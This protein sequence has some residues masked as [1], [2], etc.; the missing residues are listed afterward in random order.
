VS[1]EGSKLIGK[2]ISHYIILEKLGGGG[3]GE[4]YKA[5]DTKLERTIALKF[6]PPEFTRDPESK[7][8]FIHEAKVASKLEHINICNIH[9]IDE[10][11]DGQIFIAMACYDG[12]TL[13]DKIKNQRLKTEDVIDTAI[14][15]AQGLAKAHE[16]GITHCDIKPANIFITK[17][18][19]V[20]IVDFGIAKL[21]GQTM[22]TKIGMTAGTVAYMSPEQARGDI[23]DRRTDIWSLG[24]V[25]YE[26]LTNQLPFKGNYEQALVYSILNEEPEPMTNVRSELPVELEAVAK[27]MLQKNLEE[28]YENCQKLLADLKSIKCNIEMDFVEHKEKPLPSV[29]VLPFLNMSTDPEN[30]YFSE[31]LA[32][33]LIN[34]LSKINDF[35]IAA[36][37]S[38]F[39]FKGER[40]DIREIGQK[41]NV[42]TVLEGSVRKAG[43]RLR[44]T[45]Q[46]INVRDGYHLWSEQYNKVLADVFDIQDE[47]TMAIVEAL[48]VQ[49]LAGENQ[50]IKKRYTDNI[51]AYNLYLKGRYYWNKMTIE[52]FRNAINHFQRAIAKDSTYALA[53]AGLAD[54][55]TGLGDAGLSAIPPKEAFLN[56]KVA[57]QKALEIDE[58][59]AE[60]HASLGHLKMH[61]FDWAGA[62]REFKRAIEL[63]PNYA[64]T[65]HMCG[66]YFALMGKHHEAISYMR[67]ALELDP[68]SLGINTDLGV[69]FYF[70]GQ[71]D[72]AIA[73]HR[74]TLEMD[75]GFIRAYVT[76]GS[77]YGQKGMYKEAID[78]F[79]KALELSGDRLKIAALAR[80]YARAGKREKA[81]QIIEELEQLSRQRYISPYC[82][83]LI[84][85]SLDERDKAMEWLQKAYEK[86][87]SELIYMKVDPY[88][89]NLRSDPRFTKLLK[90]IGLEK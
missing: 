40:I 6:L 39:S 10:A 58:A 43:N 86:H 84:Y 52:S 33:D 35:R 83:A 62:E 44:I 1:T 36:R 15:I 34:A 49:L 4:I 77:T 88:L 26:M 12:E 32:E 46:L 30:E 89:D 27:K 54:S 2:T 79:E 5:E 65:Y 3:M 87:V 22:L 53:Y 66:F 78:A 76:L 28:R 38:T 41:L 21:T 20:K 47:I 18:N 51:E 45:A 60:A 70:A 59:L 67:R 68:V 8:R 80:A 57:V 85:A 90:K 50:A 19:I 25:F 48:K 17:D 69:L 16:K 61:D 56:A 7:K 81:L 74:K 63:N 55:Y 11:E 13:E 64:T 72:Q 42:Q 9:E 82:I 29:A 23:V 37:T 31:G 75:P 14:Q 24:I 73:Q 71:Y